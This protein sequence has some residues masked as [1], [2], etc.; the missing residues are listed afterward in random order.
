[1]LDYKVMD[2]VEKG[3]LKTISFKNFQP[4]QT[5]PLCQSFRS[6]YLLGKR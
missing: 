2:T 5:P 6:I 1:M 4:D 3:K